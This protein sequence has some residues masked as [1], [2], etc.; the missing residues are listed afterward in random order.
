VGAG[1]A[2]WAVGEAV[3]GVQTG[4]CG[5][6]YWCAHEQEELCSTIMERAVWGAYA[7]YLALP[8]FIVRQNLYRK[9]AD[10]PFAEAALLEPL[11]SVMRGQRALA[12]R[13]D[14]SVLVVG[15]G[16]IGLLHL[17]ALRAAGVQDLHVSGRHAARLALA[18][19]LGAAV[20]D[21]DTTDVSA[22]IRA[23]TG[24]RGAD[25]VIECTGQ[26][27][28]WAQAVGWARRGGQVCLFGGCPAGSTV[29]WETGRLHYDGVRVVSP[30]HFT[31]RDVRAAYDLLLAASGPAG[32]FRRL[33][34]AH[35]PLAALPAVFAQLRAGE[36]VKY[37]IET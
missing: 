29:T 36:G 15:A 33:L 6:C 22:A 14:D 30:F 16:P 26:P 25:V 8:A 7:E 34:T 3:M 28:V 18:A 1:V 19:D 11:A 31:P 12:L 20:Y 35:A 21:A 27:A 2:G 4:P 9:P 23:A 17:I 32:P 10:L 5:T 24:G 13:P 37:V